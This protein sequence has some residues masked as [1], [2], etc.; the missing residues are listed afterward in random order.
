VRGAGGQRA[1][2]GGGGEVRAV[3]RWA[4]D[5][6]NAALAGRELPPD[7]VF[8]ADQRITWWAG[9][10]R[11]AGLDG[12][13]DELRTRALL[14]LLLGRD[15]RPGQDGAGTAPA[16]SSASGFAGTAPGIS[17]AGGFAGRVALTVPLATLAGLADRPGE[18]PGFGPVDPWPARDL[19]AAAAG[20]PKTTWWC[21]RP[22]GQCDFEHN[23]AYE[24]GGRTCLCN[25]G[26]K[27]RRDHRLKQDPRWTVSQLPDGTFRRTTRTGRAY[28]TEPTR[29]PI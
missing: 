15:S 2:A 14:D 23:T 6:G 18:I 16:A 9:E 19:A 21:R 5:S 26:P 11:R 25:A 3:E 1:A 29:Y 4:E 27:C 20:N 10:L 12:G 7:E 22:A 8:A 13:I 28:T 24:A 17:P